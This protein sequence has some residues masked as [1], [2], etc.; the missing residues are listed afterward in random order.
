[1]AIQVDTKHHREQSAATPAQA[2]RPVGSGKGGKKPVANAAPVAAARNR[3]VV[4]PTRDR[5]RLENTALAP[6]LVYVDESG[7][8]LTV[9]RNVF[10]CLGVAVSDAGAS[11]LESALATIGKLRTVPAFPVLRLSPEGVDNEAAIVSR[12]VEG[13]IRRLATFTGSIAA[14]LAALRREREVLF[15]NYRALEDAFRAR[16]WDAATEVFAHD[17]FVDPKEEGIG[18]LLRQSTV[19]Q[20]LPVS[21]YGV[22][23]FALH[24]RRL[25]DA[26]G[27]LVV[28]LDYLETGEGIAEWIIPFASIA[29]NWNYFSL[30]R[31]C[32]GS[33]RTLR[34]RLSA[35]GGQPSEPSLGH[36]ISN[37]R[38]TASADAVHGDLGHRPLAFRVFTG[39]P[40]AR[41]ASMPG[42]F[43]PSELL[44]GRRIEDYRLPA[45]VLH[46]VANVSATPLV[47]DF[48]TVEYLE[49]EDAV[50]CHPLQQGISAA[51]LGGVVQPGTIRLSAR[52]RIDHPDGRPA[53]IG[54]LLAPETADLRVEIAE[55]GRRG[56]APASSLFSGW[57]SV[58]PEQPV[59]INVFLDAPLPRAMT[60]V[61]VS[62]AIQDSVDFCWLKVSDVRLVKQVGAAAAAKVAAKAAAK[63]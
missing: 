31:A 5:A 10:P 8:A 16:N 13:S 47:P 57:R 21:S 11:D 48:Q 62:R 19:E 54:V 51:A 63:A 56:T 20:L 6:V 49:H 37:E 41:P 33:Q 43:A 36:P 18:Q 40:G 14:E 35:T 24:F 26:K 45:S 9:L 34:L 30:P 4:A 29:P 23:G 15:D 3:L 27:E 39:L 52:A 1:M 58:T 53:A 32:D 60:L 28:R 22:S 17:P 38:Y 59:N 25:S 42:M 12:V 61:V 55:L 2:P 44:E 50:I 7:D 46:T